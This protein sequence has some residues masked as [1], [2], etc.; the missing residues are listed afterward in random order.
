[1]KKWISLLLL[2]ISF[3]S[4]TLTPQTAHAE[5]DEWKTLTLIQTQKGKWVVYE[6]FAYYPSNNDGVYFKAAD[7]CKALG[8]S[9]KESSKTLTITYG[10]KKLTYTANSKKYTYYDGKSTTNLTSNYKAYIS[11]GSFMI[12][13]QTLKNIIGYK[14]KSEIS[15]TSYRNYGVV[16]MFSTITN[17]PG[18]PNITSLYDISGQKWAYK[19]YPTVKVSSVSFPSL[20]EFAKAPLSSSSKFWA[21]DKEGDTPFEDA[22]AKYN[23]NLLAAIID[24]GTNE[25][26]CDYA[27]IKVSDKA[28][29]AEINCNTTIET[30]RLYKKG[31]HY[32][33]YISGSLG[34][35]EYGFIDYSSV[36]QDILKIYCKAISS[37][38]D[39]LYKAI[40]NSW[41]NGEDNI[42]K[43]SWTTIG[44]AMVT[45]RIENKD[46]GVYSIKAK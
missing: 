28:I 42:S 22:L 38:P 16:F 13:G 5:E 32:E 44:D 37:T 36:L 31:D 3:I 35:P 40:Y 2:A 24:V 29:I 15:A 26:S 30:I 17:N 34:K 23:E 11:K 6:D 39:E 20:S 12:E 46:A 27:S 25:Q 1:M 45:Y 4:I 10:K 8:L 21:A 41:Q 9:Y 14:H 33:I 19:N 43:K 18:L 7:L